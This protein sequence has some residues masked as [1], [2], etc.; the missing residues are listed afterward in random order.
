M[1]GVDGYMVKTDAR[2]NLT[3]TIVED[4]PSKNGVVSDRYSLPAKMGT[5]LGGMGVRVV[6]VGQMCEASVAVP[7]TFSYFAHASDPSLVS[8]FYN[9][10]CRLF[11]HMLLTPTYSAVKQ[12]FNYNEPFECYFSLQPL[13]QR[14]F[15]CG[16]DGSL[17]CLTRI[18]NEA[19]RVLQR[20]GTCIDNYNDNVRVELRE[21]VSEDGTRPNH[22]GITTIPHYKARRVAL[23]T[24]TV[25]ESYTLHL[26]TLQQFLSLPADVREKVVTT[27]IQGENAS[28]VTA[29]SLLE[30]IL[31]CRGL[32]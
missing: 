12:V 5:R 1:G 23:D 24:R 32:C 29:G 19:S 28:P 27:F 30:L 25:P 7:T 3:M 16:L 6:P 18:P 26:R 21:R 13:S 31:S 9:R 2:R 20:L 11:N 15:V 17:Q 22:P 8:N 10:P 4:K 14:F